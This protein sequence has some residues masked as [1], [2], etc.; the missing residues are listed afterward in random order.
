M[1]KILTDRERTIA[2]DWLLGRKFPQHDT[3]EQI[4]RE[5]PDIWNR[6]DNIW[7][8]AIHAARQPEQERLLGLPDSELLSE[9]SA[10]VVK[11]QTTE[12]LKAEGFARIE[13]EEQERA[14]KALLGKQHSE[15]QAEKA[16][17]PRPT[18]IDGQSLDDL[19]RQLRDMTPAEAWP[20]LGSA[21]DQWAGSCKEVRLDENDRQRWSYE[22]Q[23]EDGAPDT[24][25]YQS[26]RKKLSKA[27]NE[28]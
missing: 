24:I 3:H 20:H 8:R 27:R 1:D 4:R 26:F 9:L 21:I 22:F 13:A 23:R 6:S 5:Y 17:K 25:G 18:I 12:K 15:T 19:I 16:R 7:D 28:R 14:V 2:M 11:A 10:E